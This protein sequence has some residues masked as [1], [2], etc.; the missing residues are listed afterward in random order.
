ML[1]PTWVLAATGRCLGAAGREGLPRRHPPACL[2]WAGGV[3]TQSESLRRR[4]TKEHVPSLSCPETWVQSWNLLQPQQ[5]PMRQLSADHLPSFR[6]AG[7][8]QKTWLYSR[9]SPGDKGLAAGCAGGGAG[10]GG[11]R[12]GV[13]EG[14]G[15]NGTHFAVAVA[16]E[17]LQLPVVEFNPTSHITRYYAAARKEK[18]LTN[19]LREN[20]QIFIGCYPWAE[21]NLFPFCLFSTQVHEKSLVQMCRGKV[22]GCAET[23]RLCCV[24]RCPLPRPQGCQGVW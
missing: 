7:Q 1:E 4:G 13:G 20:S 10:W 15:P 3:N 12:R 2:W 6:A 16:G 19:T 11:T 18:L 24:L 9:G 14:D 5:E 21:A 8:T 23:T 17:D 22:Q